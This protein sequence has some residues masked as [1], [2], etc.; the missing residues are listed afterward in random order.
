MNHNPETFTQYRRALHQAVNDPKTVAWAQR[1]TEGRYLYSDSA[2]AV[3]QAII[4]HK[5]PFKIVV[6]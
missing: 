5:P 3:A 1:V 4:D 2:K 6:K